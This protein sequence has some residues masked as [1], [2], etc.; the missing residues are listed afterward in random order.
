MFKPD[1]MIGPYTLVRRLGKGAFGVVW[2]AEKRT[3]IATTKVAIK[4]ASDDH[5]DLEAVQREATVWVSASGHPNVLPIIDADVYNDQIIIVSEYAPDGSLARWL[6]NHG[7]KAPSVDAAVDMISGILAGLEHLHRR[8]II[9]RDLKPDNILL[10]GD[11]PRLA[12]FGIA[13]VLKATSHST[14]VSGTPVYMPPEAFDGK[15]S[16]QTDIWSAGVILYQLLTGRL[17]FHG[18][19]MTSLIGSIV[20]RKPEPLPQA[21]PGQLGEVINRSLKKDAAD[22]YGTVREMRHSL[23]H[24]GSQSFDNDRSLADENDEN[25]SF[26]PTLRGPVPTDTERA[27]GSTKVG[28]LDAT[29]S[30]GDSPTIEAKRK[31]IRR[32]IA[33]SAIVAAAAIIIGAGILYFRNSL[34][35]APA[36]SETQITDVFRG[37]TGAWVDRIF[38]AQVPKGG[39]KELSAEDESAQVWSTAQCI[40]SVLASQK[41]DLG[42]YVAKIKKAFGFIEET[43][44]TD[45]SP[46]WNYY[47]NSSP[48]T[49]TEITGWVV[50]AQIKS[51]ESKTQI[52]DAT[53]REEI[54]KRIVRDLDEL[55]F[56]QDNNGGWRTIRDDQP[57]FIRTYSSMIALWSLIEARRSPAVY[58][59]V[60]SRYDDSIRRGLNWFLLTYKPGQ[61]W[62]QNP[63]R[64]GQVAAYEGLTTQALF[65]LSRAET[66]DAFSF[67]K[68]E[69]VYINAK[70]ELIANRQLATRSV[71]KDNSSI[72]DID[73]RFGGS[74]FMAEGSTFLWFPWT[75]A[76][77]SQLSRDESLT[78][79]DRKAAATLR[80]DILNS[81][82][83]RLQNF[84]ET[85]NLMY[86]VA[87]NLFCASVYLETTQPGV[88][89]P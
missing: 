2:L 35:T 43:R 6:D 50:L 58:E 71:D 11:T 34:A 13:R 5:I 32:A 1:S 41:K 61:G 74:E 33:L 15:R 81:N 12:D 83:D 76:E 88:V 66:M 47:G 67:I 14:A 29:I 31:N 72:P 60:G 36:H 86:I 80:S 42:P 10:Q 37:K 27:L 23:R 54:L 77:L 44:R 18:D 40:A 59:K 28:G 25:I 4:I 17:P 21:I 49:V 55:K 73:I 26:A 84:V 87:E 48:F 24:I 16:E 69:Q 3:A 75:L 63:N 78:P 57:G 20:N 45:P 8:G 46:G 62:V 68:F 38:L 85:A 89:G 70:K 79:D 52:W 9:H 22:R 53:E 7:G 56:R 39:I 19:D 82:Y 65:V 64:V 51:V 30:G